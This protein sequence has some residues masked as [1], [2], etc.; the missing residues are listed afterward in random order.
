MKKICIGFMLLM[1]LVWFTSASA[2]TN[3]SHKSASAG[4]GKWA[5][6]GYVGYAFGFG[7]AFQDFKFGYHDPYTQEWVGYSWKNKLTFNLGRRLNTITLPS[8]LS[9]VI[10]I[11]RQ[12][13]W[14]SKQ[15]RV[16]FVM[17]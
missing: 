1:V 6:G 2:V 4:G 17:E 16:D 15:E 11:I 8:C 12:V 10:S 13:M 7:D 14:I 5:L 3:S 9:R